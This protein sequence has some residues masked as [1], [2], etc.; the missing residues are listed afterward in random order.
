VTARLTAI[1]F[2]FLGISTATW[3]VSK[4]S[5]PN[6]G[7]SFAKS[8]PEN[9]GDLRLTEAHRLVG[10]NLLVREYK[11]PTKNGEQ[12]EINVILE[13]LS[14]D[15]D[16]LAETAN[17][18]KPP[19]TGLMEY[20]IYRSFSTSNFPKAYGL[21][22]KFKVAISGPTR[23][24]QLWAFQTDG[25]KIMVVADVWNTEREA[26]ADYLEDLVTAKIFANVTYS[27]WP[28]QEKSK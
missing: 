11:G 14:V 5:W 26:Q 7:I 22:H 25:M 12:S 8:L 20:D 13:N 15:T 4:S 3:I 1:A 27:D 10:K 24:Y 18:Q 21:Y 6:N 2:I 19:Q 28:P 9:L 23:I 16:T 17:L